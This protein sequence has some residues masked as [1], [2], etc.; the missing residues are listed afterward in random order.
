MLNGIFV[1]NKPRGITSGDVVYQLRKLLHMRRVGHAGTLDPEVDGVLPVA[2]GQATK[3]I[4]RMHTKPKAYRGRGRLGL[5]TDSYDLDGKIRQQQKLTEPVSAQTLQAAMQTFV[6]DITQQ[7]PIYSA[8]KVN[9]KHLYD[10]ARAG[11]TV[12]IPTRKVHVTSYD[13]T[14]QPVFA[15]AAG[16][17]DFDFAITCSKGTY[18]RSLVNDLGVKLG[19]PAVM[20]QLTRTASSGFTLAQAVALDTLAGSGDPSQYLHPLDEFFSDLPQLTLSSDQWQQVQNGGWLHLAIN[21]KEAALSYNKKVKAIYR[22][23]A[24]QPGLYRPELMFLQN[25]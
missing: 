21:A 12:E 1:I 17:E 11:E 16:T 6:G 13:L 4:E 2:V 3:L 5:A 18:V 20:T 8:V 25:N 10:Y 19:L 14:S 22:A 7:P 15:A 9:G 23:Q 24:H